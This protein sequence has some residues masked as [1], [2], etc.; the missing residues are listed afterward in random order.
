MPSGLS[1][2]RCAVLLSVFSTFCS[3]NSI[4]SVFILS[5]SN[6]LK[7]GGTNGM[8][9]MC[10]PRHIRSDGSY[11]THVC[12][13]VLVLSFTV[14]CLRRPE[15]VGS[16]TAKVA[17]DQPGTVFSPDVIH[18]VL[19]V[20]LE[21]LCTACTRCQSLY[22]IQCSVRQHPH[23]DCHFK[24]IILHLRDRFFV[25]CVYDPIIYCS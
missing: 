8:L 17:H 16:L 11:I 24:F 1:L 7:N 15:L 19:R 2:R 10:L 5:L 9:R 25:L 21:D 18:H 4:C 3:L 6:V 14:V 22:T 23:S 12:M 20:A 13:L